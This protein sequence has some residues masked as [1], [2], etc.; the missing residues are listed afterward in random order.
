MQRVLILILLTTSLQSLAQNQHMNWF[1]GNGN[2]LSF[3]SGNPAALTGGSMITQESCAVASDADGNLLFYTNGVNVWDANHNL[4]PNGSGLLGNISAQ[5]MIIPKPG[6]S[7]LY[8][9]L[10]TGAANNIPASGLTYSEV[11]LTM[12]GGM[13]DVT[14]SKNITLSAQCGEWLTAVP[15]GNC[16]DTWIL[17]HG[18]SSNSVFMAFHVSDSG[19]NPVPVSTNLGFS[20][21]FGFETVGLMKPHPSGSPVVMTRPLFNGRVELIDFDNSTGIATGTTNLYTATN[22]NFAYGIEFSRS[23]NKLY[24]GEFSGKIFQYNMTAS[25][26]AATRTQVGMLSVPG[27]VGLLQ[28]AP[29]DKIYVGYNIFPAGANF[30]GVINIP[31]AGGPACGFVQNGVSL[32]GV[33]IYGLPWYYNPDY[34]GTAV[35]PDISADSILCPGGTL[36]LDPQ[37]PGGFTGSVIWSDGSTAPTLDINTTGAW[38]VTVQSGNCPPYSDTVVV[39]LDTTAISME[40]V[41][42]SGCS[43][44]KTSFEGQTNAP[45]L[46]W[47]WNMGNGVQFSQQNVNYTYTVPGIYTVTLSGLSQFHCP[48]GTSVAATI[49]VFEVPEASFSY[50]PVP[51]QSGEP[52]MFTDQSQ[53]SIASWQWTM[54]EMQVS[55]QPEW[56]LIMES[57][58]PFEL[59]LTVTTVNGCSDA[60]ARTIEFAPEDLLYVPNAFTPDGNGDNDVF[61][62]EDHYGIIRE[63]RIYNRWGELIWSADSGNASWDGTC[64]GKPALPDVYVW[65]IS[66]ALNGV[67]HRVIHGHVTLIR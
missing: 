39:R 4:M 18:H 48:V 61:H 31:E 63:I 52:V 10:A 58:D 45:L 13:G 29:N 36:T 20:I 53:G 22:N 1:F 11:D 43:P 62:A 8:Y 42:I 56:Q 57:A 24:T 33:N 2:G 51:G 34:N 38:W 60:I 3:T 66:T 26:I 14:A 64:K 28:I 59:G 50:S 5:C 44:V 30:I 35:L 46:F 9:I 7:S 37:I 25:T 41:S 54:N 15:H 49:E 65:E 21:P 6:S 12:N 67:A 47:S 17:T 16:A 40:P 27:E 19:I 55:T 23:G 32:P